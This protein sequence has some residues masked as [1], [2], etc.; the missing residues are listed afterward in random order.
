MSGARAARRARGSDRLPD[1]SPPDTRRTALRASFETAQEKAR[2]I[3]HGRRRAPGLLK[4]QT[5]LFR[6]YALVRY[7]NKRDGAGCQQ[8]LVGNSL[9]SPKSCGRDADNEAR[10]LLNP[11]APV[12]K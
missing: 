6:V 11:E 8:Q 9:K 3:P 4:R 12:R 2:R 1:A 10:R 5:M 7:P